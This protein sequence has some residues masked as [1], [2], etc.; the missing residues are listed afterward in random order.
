[1]A[2]G[3]LCNAQLR[4]Y[5]PRDHA[6]L[7]RL[8]Q[9]GRAPRPALVVTDGVFSMDGDLA[10]LPELDREAE[11]AGA[12]VVV[13]DAH[14]TGVTGATARGLVEHFG[15]ENPHLVQMG[16]LSRRLRSLGR[17]VPGSRALIEFLA[18]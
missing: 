2:A 1:M 9:R 5:R 11:Q 17:F 4:V 13:D 8:L 12:T 10:P 14:G 18:N 3:R 16:T 15:L 7:T 6:Q